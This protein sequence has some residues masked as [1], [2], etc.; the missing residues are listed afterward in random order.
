MHLVTLATPTGRSPNAPQPPGQ[1]AIL[2]ALDLPEPPR[3]FEF[4]MPDHD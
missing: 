1:K 2:A 3:F 4:T